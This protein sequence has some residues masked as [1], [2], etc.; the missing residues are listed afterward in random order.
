MGIPICIQWFPYA[1]GGL[2]TN[3]SPCAYGDHHMHTGIPIILEQSLYAYGDFNMHTGIAI[4]I[5]GYNSGLIPICRWGLPYA[6]GDLPLLPMILCMHM[7]IPVCIRQ[8]PHLYGD[9][10]FTTFTYANGDCRMHTVITI[11]MLESL[12][13]YRDA[14]C[15][16]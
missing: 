13:V 1:Y 16:N 9:T 7:G 11:C 2:T 4:C 12:F 6:Y 8:S 14:P 5:W 10:T 15:A 3:S